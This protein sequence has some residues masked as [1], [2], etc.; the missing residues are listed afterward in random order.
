MKYEEQIK[1]IK[2]KLEEAKRV[3]VYLEEAGADSHEYKLGP[4]LSE[5]EVKAFE[6]KYSIELPDCY[7][8]FLL[9]IGNGGR[10]YYDS[11]AGPALGIYPLALLEEVTDTPEASLK[12]PVTL[13]PG[14]TQAEWEEFAPNLASDEDTP[15]EI[16]DKEL[17]RAFGGLFSIGAVRPVHNNAIALNGEY[18]GRVINVYEFGLPFYYSQEN[19]LDWYEAWLDH[20]INRFG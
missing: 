12:N 17:S 7:R 15:D 18:K 3:D 20:V 16:Y 10:G 9:H 2:E 14:M 1:R 19:F 4:T 5:E 11:G 13:W 6:D 8:A